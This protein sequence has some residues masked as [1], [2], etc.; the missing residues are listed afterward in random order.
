LDRTLEFRARNCRSVCLRCIALFFLAALLHAADDP[1]PLGVLVDA[2][3]YRVH[4]NCTGSG[5]PTVVVAGGGFSFDWGLVQ[6]KIATLTRVCTY[7]PSGTAWS[8]PFPGQRTPACADRVTELHEVLQRASVSGPVV[9]VGY[10][11]GGLYARLYASRYP[12]EVEGMVIVDHAFSEPAPVPQTHEASAH[13]PPADGVFSVEDVDTPPSLISRTPVK[14]GIEDDRN[15]QRLP[16]RDQD[17]HAWAM[18]GNPLRPN[19]ETLAEC[20][21]AV[22]KVEKPYP[23]GAKPLLVISTNNDSPAYRQL[24]TQL[25]HLSRDSKHRIAE[26]STHMVLVDEPEA[27]VTAI[28]D[29]VQSIRNHAPLN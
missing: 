11:I 2:G 6:P 18:S 19:G 21:T 13:T 10:S 17:L 25:L 16:K 1:A 27:I 23:L 28:E 24:Q 29:V 12:R 4:L 26:H 7:D 8:D 3:G 20:T 15:F 5:S 22:E 9:L 14:L